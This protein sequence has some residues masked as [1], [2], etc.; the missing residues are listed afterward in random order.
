[1]EVTS[2][3]A[4][5]LPSTAPSRRGQWK[6]IAL[7]VLMLVL[8]VAHAPS[9]GA[10]VHKWQHDPQYSHGYLVPVFALVLL[11]KRRALYQPGQ[12]CYSWWALAL[13][14][15]SE[16]TR[17]AAGHYGL[18]WPEAITVVSSIFAL[19]WLVG[20]RP[21]LRWAWP[22]IGF[23]V[24]MIPLPYRVEVSMAAPLQR[25]A[26][27]AS[28]YALQTLGLPAVPEG[29]NI[30][31]GEVT[32]GIVEACSGLRMLVVFVALAAAVCLWTPRP[33]P[34]QCAILLSAVP[35]AIVTN[36]LRITATGMLHVYTSSELA[37]LVFH[38][39]AGWLMMPCALA[40]LAIELWLL[41][42]TWIQESG[43]GIRG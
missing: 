8:L 2:P 24:F 30:L 35:I 9:L 19:V 25:L 10:T 28:A 23:L 4:S 7:A 33:L 27:E 13:L 31:I 21:A 14:A 37:N 42:R 20:G 1:M 3:T 29:N 12:W 43:V 40:F 6:V 39:L 22:A 26:T 34:D 41:E 38:D 18:V 16:A 11:W 36:V 17:L 15:A 32:L 5:T